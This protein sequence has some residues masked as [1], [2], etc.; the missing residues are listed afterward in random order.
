MILAFKMPGP[1]PAAGINKEAADVAAVR[2]A[3][4]RQRLNFCAV[5]YGADNG[6][7][8][9]P[10][11]LRMKPFLLDQISS[12]NLLVSSSAPSDAY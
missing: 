10:L 11:Q 1:D 2:L 6:T 5:I 7:G 4:L 9:H 3:G 12:L 8:L